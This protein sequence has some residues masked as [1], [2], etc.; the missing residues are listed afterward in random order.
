MT[1]RMFP[2][3][4][5]QG[6]RRSSWKTALILRPVR[7]S[8]RPLSGFSSPMRMRSSVVLPAPEG[9]IR[10]LTRPAGKRRHTSRSTGLP[11]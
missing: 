11:S 9:A 6:R 3:V 10:Q 2:A 4:L 8:T 1:K 7:P 5:P